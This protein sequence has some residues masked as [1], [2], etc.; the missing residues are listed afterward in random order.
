L[1]LSIFVV[2]LFSLQE[3]NLG[4]CFLQRLFFVAGRAA[5]AACCRFVVCSSASWRSSS[6]MLL[7]QLQMEADVVGP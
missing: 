3:L 5:R 2:F 4:Q 1:R 6:P 7:R